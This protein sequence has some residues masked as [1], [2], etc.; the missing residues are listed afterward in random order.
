MPCRAL[1]ATVKEAA[2]VSIGNIAPRIR[3]DARS[4]SDGKG[5]GP[6]PTAPAEASSSRRGGPLETPTSPDP[7]RRS[8]S[9]HLVLDADSIPQ[10]PFRPSTRCLGD[11]LASPAGWRCGTA[12]LARAGRAAGQI[13]DAGDRHPVR[14]G[15]KAR[16]TGA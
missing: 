8:L 1:S 5:T 7:P 12:R 9:A 13:P 16:G 2:R 14:A 4:S 6:V 10:L 15:G 11:R 3:P